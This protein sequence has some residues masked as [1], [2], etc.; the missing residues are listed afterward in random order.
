MSSVP[1]N[2]RKPRQAGKHAWFYINRASIDVCHDIGNNT[3]IRLTRKQL[4]SALRVMDS[5][6]DAGV[7]HGL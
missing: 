4:E 6:S 5:Q 3:F 7:K 2:M 1:A